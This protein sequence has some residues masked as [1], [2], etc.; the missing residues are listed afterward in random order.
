MSEPKPRQDWRTSYAAAM[1]ESDST[2]FSDLI[3]SA[4]EAIHTRLRELPETTAIHFE[5][6]ELRLA[7]KYLNLLKSNSK[8]L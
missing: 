3:E 5:Y 1:L 2:Q 7:L 8:A 4:S 6:A